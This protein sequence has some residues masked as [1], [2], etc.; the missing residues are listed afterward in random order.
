[1]DAPIAARGA[2]E[3]ATARSEGPMNG[4]LAPS[5]VHPHV[6]H[7]DGQEVRRVQGGGAVEADTGYRVGQL[8]GSSRMC[9]DGPSRR[10][11]PRLSGTVLG[12]VRMSWGRVWP[13]C[14]CAE[15]AERGREWA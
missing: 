12:A 5:V 7:D 8:V 11:S 14:F 1:M 2:A 15:P 6:E 13:A 4:A 3:E 9:K 10:V